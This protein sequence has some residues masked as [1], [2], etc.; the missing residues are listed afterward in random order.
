MSRLELAPWRMKIQPKIR[1]LIGLQITYLLILKEWNR[2]IFAAISWLIG[3][4]SDL[5]LGAKT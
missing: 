4:I 2:D 3:T 1:G 5:L